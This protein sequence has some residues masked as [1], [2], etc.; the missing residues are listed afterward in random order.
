[1]RRSK[2][3]TGYGDETG[4]VKLYRMKFIPANQGVVLFAPKSPVADGT[5]TKM[6]VVPA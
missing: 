1:M 3:E 4:T 2:N 5:K 6:E